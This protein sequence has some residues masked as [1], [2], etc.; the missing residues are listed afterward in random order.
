MPKKKIK[1]EA[2]ITIHRLFTIERISNHIFRNIENPSVYY[3]EIPCKPEWD[4]F[5]KITHYIRGNIDKYS[6]DAALG[7]IYLK[8]LHDIIRIYGP[9]MAIDQLELVSERYLYE[10]EHPDH[11]GC[12]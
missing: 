1:G 7:S 4:P 9:G 2:R 11:L 8:E 10:F 6:F 3:F 12:L 5:K